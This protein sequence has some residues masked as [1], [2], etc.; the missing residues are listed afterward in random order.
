MKPRGIAYRSREMRDRRRLGH[1]GFVRR[2]FTLPVGA[3]QG[4]RDS[5]GIPGRGLHDDR[6]TLA[7]AA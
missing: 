5:S 7:P 6:R 1:D 2:T 4:A 3:S